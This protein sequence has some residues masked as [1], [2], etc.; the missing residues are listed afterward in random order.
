MSI[1]RGKFI[2]C[3]DLH[4]RYTNAYGKKHRLM[5]LYRTEKTNGVDIHTC[6]DFAVTTGGLFN[7]SSWLIF[8]KI[9]L[10]EWTDLGGITTAGNHD[11]GN[12][13]GSL[14]VTDGNVEYTPKEYWM[15]KTG[16][17]SDLIIQREFNNGRDIL[18]SISENTGGVSGYAQSTID[19]VKGIFASNPDKRI[20]VFMHYPC[21]KQVDNTTTTYTITANGS[22]TE[23]TFPKNSFATRYGTGQ[24]GNWVNPNAYPQPT[25]FLTWLS[26]QANAIIISGHTHNDWRLQEEKLTYT[27]KGT[28]YVGGEFP[29]LKYYHVPGGAY[30]INIPSIRYRTQDAM[31]SVFD[32][33]IEI[34]GRAG[35]YIESGAYVNGEVDEMNDDDSWEIRDLGAVYKYTIPLAEQATTKVVGY[36]FDGAEITEEGGFKY[37][38]EKCDKYYRW[39]GEII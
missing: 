2:V 17:N 18:L 33:K 30:M 4:S 26:N 1:L 20:F 10:D 25:E 8:Y 14:N 22:V 23:K 29:N 24:T 21:W 38:G 28:V 13:F 37:S 36:K 19:Y 6:G 15:K 32:D 7:S 39:N 34:Q 5:E 35:V 3:S 11:S 27:V 9:F 31:F 12:D 16:A